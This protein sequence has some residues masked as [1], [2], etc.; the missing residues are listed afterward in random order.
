[1]PRRWIKTIIFSLLLVNL[2]AFYL[3]H[4]Y[5]SPVE[6]SLFFRIVLTLLIIWIWYSAYKKDQYEQLIIITFFLTVFNLNKLYLGISIP[7]AIILLLA[8][9]LSSGLFYTSIR[10]HMAHSHHLVLL[11]SLL[12]G[13]ISAES[14]LATSI[15]SPNSVTLSAIVSISFYCIWH[16]ILNHLNHKLTRSASIQY[17]VYCFVA[18]ILIISTTSWYNSF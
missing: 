13:L 1:M 10:L 6:N 4:I 7:I 11:Y 16:L 14:F 17:T 15:W 8:A 3:F 2:S 5:I 18:I 12:I 9:I